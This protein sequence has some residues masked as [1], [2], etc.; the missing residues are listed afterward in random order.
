MKKY[1]ALFVLLAAPAIAAVDC[2][3]LPDCEAYGYT[4][5]ADDCSG[6]KTLSC[7]FDE[8]KKICWPEAK[9]CE[10][11]SLLFDDLKCYDAACGREPIAIV[12]NTD[13]RVALQLATP[14]SKVWS[15]LIV[16]VNGADDNCTNVEDAKTTCRTDG[17]LNTKEIMEFAKA[18]PDHSFP[19][20]EYCY[21]LTF[22]NQ[23]EGSWY[24][25]SLKELFYVV[26]NYPMIA[27]MFTLRGLDMKSGSWMWTSV[28]TNGE[29]SHWGI[30]STG[31]TRNNN[32]SSKRSNSWWVHCMI[33]Y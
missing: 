18:N 29:Y 25:P 12:V 4:C 1:I 15:P 6:L 17:K 11:G 2:Q 22:G 20:V 8:S 19:A 7:P 16:D 21:T 24:L 30:Y 26:D 32:S 5:S 23:P 31:Y 10:V 13:E 27:N 9:E 33:R 14:V 28:E 3:Q